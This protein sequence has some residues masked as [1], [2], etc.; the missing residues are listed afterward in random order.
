MTEDTE[1]DVIQRLVRNLESE[2]YEVFIQPSRTLLPDFLGSYVPDVIARRK[3]GNLAIEVKRK[4]TSAERSVEDLARLFEGRKDWT[5]RLV[6][7]EPTA[8][9]RSLEVQSRDTV[10]D[11]ISEIRQLVDGNHLSSALL[12]GW[13]TLEAVGRM[14]VSQQ[15]QRPQT[16]GRLVQVL[17]SEGYLTPTEADALRRLADKRNRIIHGELQTDISKN[18]IDIVT[19]VLETIVTLADQ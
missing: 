19:N 5:L 18:D 13:A 8:L 9:Q 4:S 1:Q 14:L 11:Q 2:G 7:I 15:F 17:A 3:D 6:W 10:Q 12:L 16:P